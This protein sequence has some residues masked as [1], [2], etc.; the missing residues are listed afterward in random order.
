MQIVVCID[1]IWK[2]ERVL[3]SWLMDVR[4]GFLHRRLSWAGVPDLEF[5]GVSGVLPRS[6]SFNGNGFAFIGEPRWRPA[7]LHISNGAAS[8]SDMEVIRHVLLWWLLWWC[9][10][11]V[12]GVG[13]KFRGF[14]GLNC[15]FTSWLLFLYAKG[16]DLLSFQFYQVGMY[17]ACTMI[18]VI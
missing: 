16:S 3:G 7:K 11:Q 4:C 5:D 9:Q 1:G 13:V 2:M 18:L 17:V 12:T 14:F 8:S 15:N 6:D 10:R